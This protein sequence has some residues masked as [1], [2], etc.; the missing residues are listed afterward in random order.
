MS[1]LIFEEMGLYLLYLTL[2]FAR[3]D[4]YFV[5]ELICLGKK[6]PGPP[7]G[8]QVQIGPGP[9]WDPGPN[10]AGPKWDPGPNRAGPKWDPV[11][12]RAGP[13]WDPGPNGTL[14]Q[15]LSVVAFSERIGQGN[16][17]DM[18]ICGLSSARFLL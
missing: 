7:N 17:I 4:L 10:R 9:K 2:Y 11:P 15:N 8:T 14:T 1:G 6:G 3:I 12:N 13:K 18:A 5:S 16:K